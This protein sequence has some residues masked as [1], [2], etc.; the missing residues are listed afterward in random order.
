[1]SIGGEFV[2]SESGQWMDSVNPATGEVHGRVPAGTAADVDRA[3][4]SVRA[5]QPSW[6]AT[7]VFERGAILRKLAEAIRARKDVLEL[8]AADTGNTIASLGRDLDLAAAYLNFVAGLGMEIKGE[9]VPATPENIHFTMREPYGVVGRIVPFNHPFLFAAAHLGAPLIAG[10][11]VVLKSPD[12]SP[13][14]AK[15]MAEICHDILPPGLVNF[16]SGVGTVVGDAIVRHPLVPRIGFTGSVQTGMAI[17]RSAA[18]VAVKHVSLELGG[19]N[20]FIAFADAD[21]GE[22][23]DAAVAGMNF[24]WS[25]QS[26]GSTSRLMLHESIYDDVVSRIAAQVSGIHLGDPLD[27]ESGMGPVNSEAHYRRILDIIASAK[28]QGATVIAGGGKPTGDRFA[29]GFWVEPTVFGDVTMQMR[30]AREEI[31]G[32]VLA[33]LKWRDE[34]D[35]LAMANDLDL[36]LTAAVWTNDLKRAMRTV[37]RLESGLVWVNGTGRHYL[38][39]GFSGWKDSGLGREECLEEVLSYTR[40]KA[41]HVIL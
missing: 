24:A 26:C 16:V 14:S 9:S 41:V 1:M 6:A 27:P 2:A 4:Q 12:Q 10:N 35:V 36:G 29:R 33:V 11:G 32:P 23:A 22:V 40:V 39:T 19:K 34:E 20:P 38:G 17:Q 13:L 18:E 5:A 30:V 8:E 31:F 7:H 21:P 37:R 15:V 28:E 3:V 25:G